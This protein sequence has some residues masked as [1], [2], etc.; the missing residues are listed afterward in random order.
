M[1]GKTKALV[2]T[3][4]VGRHL[5]VEY[6]ECDAE[7]LNNLQVVKELML[8]AAKAAGTTTMGYL[9]RPFQPQG[10]TGVV[11]I[12]ES[13]LSI[14]TWPEHRY[15][16][17]DYFTCGKGK[18][19]C[20]HAVLFKGLVAKRAEQLW[21]ERGLETSPKLLIRSHMLDVQPHGDG[22]SHQRKFEVSDHPGFLAHAS[23]IASRAIE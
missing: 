14:H 13:H 3:T 5:L 7:V 12:E 11:V 16:A 21:I 6:S 18:P 22:V 2:P 10:V 8:A 17:V 15:A 9:F 23:A 20:A 19:E 1:P 4:T